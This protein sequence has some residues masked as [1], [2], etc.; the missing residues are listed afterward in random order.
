MVRLE[1]LGKFIKFDL[2]GTRTCDLPAPSIAPQPSA[3]LRS[4]II[5]IIII[6]M[7]II[8]IIIIIIIMRLIH[9]A[10]YRQSLQ[11]IIIII[12]KKGT[13]LS[14]SVSSSWTPCYKASAE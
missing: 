3:L 11:K 6:I 4:P 5:I 7:I 1:G 8:I 9:I 14:L 2:I 13:K 10:N 12:I